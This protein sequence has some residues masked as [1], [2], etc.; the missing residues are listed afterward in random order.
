MDKYLHTFQDLL[1]V[2][3]CIQRYWENSHLDLRKFYDIR[4][5]MPVETY[6]NTF[7]NLKL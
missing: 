1:M 3:F 4:L 5:A 2:I 6:Q 7:M